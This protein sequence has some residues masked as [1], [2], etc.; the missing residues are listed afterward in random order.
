MHVDQ[1][2]GR[3]VMDSVKLQLPDI[4]LRTPYSQLQATVDMDM[5]AFDEVKPGKLMAQ[6]KGALGRSDLF[7]FAGDAFPGAMKKKWPFYPMKIEGSFKGNMQQASFSGL[8]LLLP[9]AFELSADGKLG[10]LTDMNRLKANVDLKARTYHLD[11]VTAMLDP[12]LMQEIHVPSGI[13]I[14]G[15]IQ[16]DGSRY[17]TRLAITEGRGRMKVDAKVDAKTRKDGSI[18]MNRLAYQ[19]KIQAHNIQAKHFQIGRASCRERV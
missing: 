2:Y 1:L 17:A 3:F 10:N 6:L 15:N 4:C 11:F 5:N 16:A 7:L 9:T 12:S 14:R 8:K 19:A 18:D 13:G